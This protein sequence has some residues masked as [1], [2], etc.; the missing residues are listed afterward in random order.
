MQATDAQIGTDPDES[1]EGR[2]ATLLG[3]KV[4]GRLALRFAVPPDGRAGTVFCRSR[5][6]VTFCGT[7]WGRCEVPSER[8]QVSRCRGGEVRIPPPR[9][10]LLC[11]F[12]GIPLKRVN[13]RRWEQG[14]KGWDSH[15]ARDIRNERAEGPQAPQRPT[16]RDGGNGGGERAFGRECAKIGQIVRGLMAI[17]TVRWKR[18]VHLPTVAKNRCV[19]GSLATLGQLWGGTQG[20]KGAGSGRWKWFGV[21]FVIYNSARLSGVRERW[22]ER[23]LW[24]R[25]FQEA[26]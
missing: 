3:G 22:G 2:S 11:V 16:H 20:R 7:P 13:E 6:I 14:N 26:G 21:P 9:R 19:H 23:G 24:G 15:S 1:I 5:Y 17:W 8:V 10:F 4:A 25:V 18:G 12:G